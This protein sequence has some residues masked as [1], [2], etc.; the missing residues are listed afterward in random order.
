MRTRLALTAALVGA[1]LLSPS[2]ARA[3]GVEISGFAGYTFPFYSQTFAYHPGPTSV[4]IPGVSIQQSGAFAL[5]GKGGPAF[6][7]AIAFYPADTIGF[8]VRLDRAEVDVQTAST[9]FD[10]KVAL[11]G[12]L[13]PVESTLD[14]GAG[15][16]TLTA[17]R[18]LSL[19]LKLRGAGQTHLFASG[20]LSRLGSLELT[21]D[22][23]IAI[24]VAA[25]N[26]DT[27]N[28]E[29]PTLSVQ[30]KATETGSSW[31]GNLG[32]G[33]QVGLGDRGGLVIEGRGF[34]F[35]RRTVEWAG[36]NVA[37]LPAIQQ[38]LL[39]RTL[40]NLPPVEFKPWWVQATIGFSYRF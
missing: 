24:G 26:L 33:F 6:G 2:A 4:A 21:L 40:E 35:P 31:G 22:Q 30:A 3:G 34:Y 39:S 9:A 36:V 32:L 37:G 11:P 28:L 15:T 10:V 27:R 1:A 7:G 18:P 16:A 25:F 20:G 19:N 13:S 38:Q 29:I 14:L 8:E 23:T 5:E 17:P 12:G